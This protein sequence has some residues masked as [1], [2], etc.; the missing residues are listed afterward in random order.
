MDMLKKVGEIAASSGRKAVFVWDPFPGSDM[1]AQ[2]IRDP[3]KSAW[4][5]IAK[6]VDG[7]AP[8]CPL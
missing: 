8:N 3:L 6:E 5:T 4:V 7:A 1:F 2:K